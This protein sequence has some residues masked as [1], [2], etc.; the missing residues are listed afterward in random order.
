MCHPE[1]PANTVPPNVRTI[2]AAVPLSGSEP[3]PGLLALP[4]RTPAPAVLIINDIF[5]RSPFYE[6]LARRLAQAGFAGFTPEFF[7]RLGPLPEQTMEAAF[8]R[9]AN[10][11]EHQTLA[12]LGAAIDWLGAR[13]EVAGNRV[14]AIGFC[15]GGTFTLDFSALRPDLA[16]CVSYYGFP[17]AWRPTR[18]PTPLEL[19]D[20]M[21]VPI[22]GFWGDQDEGVGM[23]NVARLRESLIAAG[24]DHEIH[25]FPGVGHGFL[26]ASLEDES[27]A[28][29]EAACTSWT[30]TLDYLRQHLKALAPA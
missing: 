30:R 15:M 24:K 12:D 27:A 13:P 1:V 17:V 7:F 3:M 29:Y 4:E 9:G 19:V 20:R 11:D 25:V 22:L 23:D 21:Q 5:G 8:A 16:A 14:G 6:N 26:K 2:E 28:G 18:I 10:L